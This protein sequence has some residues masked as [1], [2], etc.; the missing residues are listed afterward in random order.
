MPLVATN[1]TTIILAVPAVPVFSYHSVLNFEIQKY[2]VH[3]AS[4]MHYNYNWKT[5]QAIYS[6]QKIP[7]HKIMD[8]KITGM[9]HEY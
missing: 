1:S 3:I 8:I 7:F 6:Y 4:Y 5:A 9:F 2:D